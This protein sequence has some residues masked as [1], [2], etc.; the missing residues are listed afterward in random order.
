VT[1]HTLRLDAAALA[2]Q[3]CNHKTALDTLSIGKIK[4][5]FTYTQ[6]T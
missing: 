4:R 3:Q 1:G 5:Y 2:H 6:G